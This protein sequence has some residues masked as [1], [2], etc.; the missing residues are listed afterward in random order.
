MG[1][2]VRNALLKEAVMATAGSEPAGP[3]GL[4]RGC[5]SLCGSEARKKSR[6]FLAGTKAGVR[7]VRNSEP[8]AAR[9]ISFD[10]D[11]HDVAFEED[12]EEAGDFRL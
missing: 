6:V 4:K 2:D 3:A 1:R 7:R 8:V 11:A 9:M 10:A 5:R 12:D